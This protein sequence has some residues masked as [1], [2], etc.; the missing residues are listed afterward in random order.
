[1]AL[2]SAMFGIR[3]RVGFGICQIR[4]GIGY[5]FQFY[6]FPVKFQNI[7]NYDNYGAGLVKGREGQAGSTEQE[8]LL[9]HF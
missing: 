2:F 9:I 6:F 1:M 5:Q 7:E 3:I 8:A 4:I